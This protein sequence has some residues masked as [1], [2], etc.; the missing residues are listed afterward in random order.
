[1]GK[2]YIFKTAW[3]K[4]VGSSNRRLDRL[5]RLAQ[6]CGEWNWKPEHAEILRTVVAQFPKARWAS[7]QLA[8]ELYSSGNTQ[9]L[10]ELLSRIY[11]EEPSNVRLK[12][13]FAN[14]SLLRKTELEKAYRLSREAY[15]SLPDDPFVVSTYSYSLLLQHR[16]D[17]ALKTV[18]KLKPEALRIPEIAGYYG[19]VQAES[20]H[21]DVAKASLER[22]EA[23]N[24]LPE[25]KELVRLARNGL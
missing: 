18:S 17:E 15:E 19:V 6:L 20:G 10:K 14:V 7:A 21:K 11:P 25:E 5:S 1:L 12:N 9:G 23:A 22:A 3:N 2:E 4:A 13:A 8:D 16:P 24:I